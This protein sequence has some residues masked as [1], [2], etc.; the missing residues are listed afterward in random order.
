MMSTKEGERG[1]AKEEWER[2]RGKAISPLE[3]QCDYHFS[4]ASRDEEAHSL[5]GTSQM[6]CFALLRS[7]E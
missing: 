5:G 3:F 2:G 7:D 4:V 6:Q 1:R